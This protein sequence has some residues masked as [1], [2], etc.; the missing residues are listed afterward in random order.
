[1]Q[2]IKVT[3]HVRNVGLYI[4]RQNGRETVVM[5]KYVVNQCPKG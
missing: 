2:D 3:E 5:N 1:M 4:V